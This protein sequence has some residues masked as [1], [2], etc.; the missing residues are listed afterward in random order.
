MGNKEKQ[1]LRDELEVIEQQIEDIK[2]EDI[3]SYKRLKE[4]LNERER[5]KFRLSI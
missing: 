3:P 5:I 2:L 1:I 4:M